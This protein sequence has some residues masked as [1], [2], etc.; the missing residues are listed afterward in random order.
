MKSKE[1]LQDSAGTDIPDSDSLQADACGPSYSY[2]SNS[3]LMLERKDQMRRRASH[4]RM[5][6]MRWRLPLPSLWWRT[7]IG[8][9]IT[10]TWIGRSFDGSAAIE[11]YHSAESIGVCPPMM[12]CILRAQAETFTSVLRVARSRRDHA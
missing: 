11:Q 2:T 5:N 12:G 4:R 10:R 8:P 3:E 9:S 1:W 6:G 7:N